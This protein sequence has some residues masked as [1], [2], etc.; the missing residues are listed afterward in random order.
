[1]GEAIQMS[2][3]S[4][5]M[6]KRFGLPFRIAHWLTA[7]SF[8][9]LYVTAL[10]MYTEFFD[11]L[12]PILGGPASARFLHRVFGITF[13]VPFFFMIFTDP[14]AL[15]HWIKSCFTWSKRDFQ[16]LL[17]FPFE[18]FGKKKGYPKQDFYNAGE[19]VN[20]LLQ[21]VCAIGIMGSGII[22]W[23]TSWFPNWLVDIGYPV[24]ALC[25]GLSA[26]VVIAHAYLGTFAPD[27]WKAFR[28][29][30]KGEVPEE[31]AKHHHGRWVDELKEDNKKKGA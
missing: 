11:W 24:H 10:P 12:W 8:I 28:G 2:K 29:M 23:N 27:G 25:V 18:F 17:A 13:M 14:K 3:S 4:E 1:M 15:F 26:A 9:M 7:F 6:I 30:V 19:K 22:I 20:S 21:M 31:W 16:F 5:R